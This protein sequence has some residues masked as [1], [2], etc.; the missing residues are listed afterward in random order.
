[1]DLEIIL[2][3]FKRISRF[4]SPARYCITILALYHNK[5]RLRE[6]NNVEELLIASP[7]SNNVTQDTHF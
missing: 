2:R 5:E 3:A 6:L 7:R 1:M 4:T